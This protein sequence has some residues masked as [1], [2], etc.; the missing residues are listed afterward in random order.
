MKQEKQ[1]MEKVKFTTSLT[2]EC[3]KRLKQLAGK[4]EIDCNAWIENMVKEQ[5]E[6]HIDE[7]VNERD[8][9]RTTE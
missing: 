6:K 7:M 2:I 4:E 3:R 9:K 1:V 5:W 8:S